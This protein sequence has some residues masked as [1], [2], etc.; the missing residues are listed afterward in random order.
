MQKLYLNLVLEY[1][2]E[3][4]AQKIR[5]SKLEGK[6]LPNDLVRAY[7]LQLFRAL[8]Y[9]EVPLCARRAST[10]ATATSS[11]RTFWWARAAR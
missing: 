11:P 3:T 5:A 1:V 6:F 2:P 10:S 9:L 8:D 7:A 4:L